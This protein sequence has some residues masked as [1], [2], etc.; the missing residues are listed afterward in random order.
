MLV[1]IMEEGQEFVVAQGGRG[2]KGNDFFKSATNRAPRHAQPGEPAI[3]RNI[4]L[5]L[6]LMADVGLVGLPNAG[7][8]TLVSSLSAA[9]P[10]I[11]DYPFTTLVPS[12]GVVSVGEYQSF[13]IADIP[14]IIEGA[15]E[16][17]GLGIQFLK[18]IERNAVLLFVLPLD[19]GTPAEEF[20]TLMA[21]LEAFNAELMYKPRMIALSK[22]DIVPPEERDRVLQEARAALPPSEDV[23]AIS[24]VARFGLDR[25]KEQ[26]WKRVQKENSEG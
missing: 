12:L 5:E 20:E 9:R 25:L 24:A 8:S 11:A 19:G 3:E 23:V 14:G 1:E 10:K 17:K 21:E 18:H 4:T 15:H 13:V 26:L 6:R 16:G 22:L 2:G 7:K